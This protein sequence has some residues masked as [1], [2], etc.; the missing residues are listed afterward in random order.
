MVSVVIAAHN[1][2]A[3]IGEC[4]DALLGQSPQPEIIVSANGCTDRTVEVAVGRGVVVIDRNEAGKAGALNAGDKVA[5]SFPRIYLDAD[6]VAPP[7]VVAALTRALESGALAAVPARR[8][9]TVGRPWPVRAYIAINT[10]LPAFREGLFGRGMIAV[11]RAGRARFHDFPAVVADDLYL[12][13]QFGPD[14]RT[15]LSDMA[16][17][18]EAPY[19]TRD[20]LARLARVR[21][22]NTQV[23]Q[24]GAGRGEVGVR[25]SD[26]WSWLRDV[27][28]TRPWLAPAAIPYVAITLIAAIQARRADTGWGTD[29]ST[30]NSRAAAS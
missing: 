5:T 29:A 25:E 28:L 4:I 21:R 17:V 24:V 11:S 22:G 9:A 3:V 15:V 1:E 18:V 20:L 7:G 6:I 12:D 13:A 23:R 27:V 30:R 19:T 2:E 14:E 26:R 16:V 10:R 8:M